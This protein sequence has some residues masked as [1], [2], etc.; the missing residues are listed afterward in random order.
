MELEG[1]ENPHVAMVLWDAEKFYDTIDLRKLVL[2]CADKAFP[3]VS[4]MSAIITL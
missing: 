4:F 2:T 1:D 3:A